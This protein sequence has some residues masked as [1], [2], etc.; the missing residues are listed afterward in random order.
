M[1]RLFSICGIFQCYGKDCKA[2]S[3]KDSYHATDF[4][5]SDLFTFSVFIVI[6]SFLLSNGKP[7][8]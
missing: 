1:F 3:A 7:L 8:V 5:V 6:V 4:D 2:T